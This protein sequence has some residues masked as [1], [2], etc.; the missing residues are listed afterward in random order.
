MIVKALH[1]KKLDKNR[2]HCY[3]CPHEC[4]IREGKYGICKSRLNRNGKLVAENFG[5]LV[6]VA[7][8][9]IEK[10]PL[11]HFYP[12]SIICSTG[13]NGCNFNCD[14]CQNWEIANT[15]VPTRF[16]SPEELSDIAQKNDSI[17]L[18]Y[19]YTEP[20]MWYEYILQTGELVKKAGLK[21]VLVTNGY[22]NPEPL[23]ELLPLIDAA[24]ID[25]KSMD[26]SF[27]RRVCKG[28]LEPILKNIKIFFEAGV[29]IELTNL[30]ITEM[31]DSRED[32]SELVDFVADISPNI[33]LHF[34]A[35]YPTYK[36]TNPPTPSS[37]LFEAYDIAREKLNFVYLGNVRVE[38][39]SDTFCPECN[40]RLIRR[41][42]YATE[43]PALKNGKCTE[44][45]FET[46]ILQAD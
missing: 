20:L 6:T 25:L 27:Y 4:K 17:G 22:I 40:T 7:F 5:E 35:Y 41:N 9:P 29:N 39:K 42:G 16:A 19:T 37:K 33:P 24:N 31:N 26:P 11:Y 38:D 36:M 23:R 2:V 8:D 30:I 45:G 3:L 34:S 44:C 14:N 1:W 21:N 18:A 15:K 28:R 13:A 43:I 12:G 32:I 46:G 10:K